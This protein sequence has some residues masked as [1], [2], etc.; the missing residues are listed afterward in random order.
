MYRV[1]CSALGSSQS[2]KVRHINLETDSFPAITRDGQ[3]PTH[4]SLQQLK[5]HKQKKSHTQNLKLNSTWVKNN[6]MHAS[7]EMMMSINTLHGKIKTMLL[8]SSCKSVRGW[9]QVGLPGECSI[10]VALP[11]RRPSS[12]VYI[13]LWQHLKK[14]LPAEL[15]GLM[16][17]AASGAE[18]PG[19][20]HKS[21][22]VWVAARRYIRK[23]ILIIRPIEQR[24]KECGES[25]SVCHFAQPFHSILNLHPMRPA[26]L[27]AAVFQMFWSLWLGTGLRIDVRILYWARV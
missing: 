9:R 25:L 5:K 14:I 27:Q 8:H 2:L 13:S 16:V 26:L 15:N 7:A 12:P 6:K 21:L 1:L 23:N 17:Y 24:T 22:W 11:R 18:D 3:F 20:I 4:G 19:F 10:A